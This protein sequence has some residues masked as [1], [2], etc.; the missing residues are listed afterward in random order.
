MASIIIPNHRPDKQ[1]RHRTTG[2]GAVAGDRRVVDR[3]RR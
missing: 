2:E 1:E 3:T